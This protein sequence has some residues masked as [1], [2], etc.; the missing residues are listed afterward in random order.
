MYVD[1]VSLIIYK[2][3]HRICS[4]IVQI[5]IAG[6]FHATRKVCQYML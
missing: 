1:I 2:N 6:H 3:L 4:D 5:L